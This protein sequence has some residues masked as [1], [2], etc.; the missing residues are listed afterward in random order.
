VDEAGN[1]GSA[2]A[3]YVAFPAE[4]GVRNHERLFDGEGSG[5]T[6]AK[7]KRQVPQPLHASLSLRKSWLLPGTLELSRSIC[8]RGSSSRGEQ[9]WQKHTDTADWRRDGR[10][11][12]GTAWGPGIGIQAPARRNDTFRSRSVRHFPCGTWAF[13]IMKNCLEAGKQKRG[14]ASKGVSR[15]LSGG[16]AARGWIFLKSG[17]WTA[18]TRVG[19][20]IKPF[21]RPEK[22]P[23]SY[24]GLPFSSGDS[25]TDT[26]ASD[27][28]A[29]APV[30]AFSA[31]H[32]IWNHDRLFDGEGSG[33][34]KAGQG[35]AKT[36]G[37]SES[38]GA[39]DRRRDGR[40][41]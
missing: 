6:K 5:R 7:P 40:P 39:A 35:G 17:P 32:G 9:G 31:E 18:D 3:P 10:H 26:G 15:L 36:Q 28:F 22:S 1:T 11:G 27:G 24:S 33:R 20:P 37:A 8:G 38:T 41:R 34:T 4:H 23:P 21:P 13:G 25:M 30:V 29:A 12:R 14:G 16:C 19:T 2:A